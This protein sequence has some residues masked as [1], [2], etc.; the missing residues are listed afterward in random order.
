MML[1]AR[2]KSIGKTA[3]VVL[4][5]AVASPGNALTRGFG[6]E[7]LVLYWRPAVGSMPSIPLDGSITVGTLANF[8]INWSTFG[9]KGG[10]IAMPHDRKRQIIKNS[11]TF[12]VI[13]ICV[14]WQDMYKMTERTFFPCHGLVGFASFINDDNNHDGCFLHHSERSVYDLG[15]SSCLCNIMHKY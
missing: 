3:R 4:I 11:K 1:R 8:W 12:M 6:C 10:S 9:S 14:R 5:V 2:A 7:S 15:C 13:E